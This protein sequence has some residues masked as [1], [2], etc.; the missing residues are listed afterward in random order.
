MDFHLPALTAIAFDDVWWEHHWWLLFPILGF[1]IAFFSIWLQHRRARDWMS[2]M[3]TYA[4]QGKEPPSSI[5]G[6]T[7]DGWGNQWG[8]RHAYYYGRRM[9]LFDLRR[10]IFFAVL[11]GAFFYLYYYRP[12]HNE[13]FGIAAV[14]VGA[15]ALGWI[16][17]SL[18][19][20]PRMD[21]P[22][23]SDGK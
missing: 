10:G 21:D 17:I 5:A 6:M 23:R 7:P 15:L 8:G 9:P 22:P 2:L 11:S 16:L 13:G 12:E 19:P 20:R 14:I 4:E 3:R 18:L 1:G